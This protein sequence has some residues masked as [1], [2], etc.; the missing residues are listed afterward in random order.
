MQISL[1]SIQEVDD[2]YQAFVDS[3]NNSGTFSKYQNNL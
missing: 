2:L 3:I 1:E